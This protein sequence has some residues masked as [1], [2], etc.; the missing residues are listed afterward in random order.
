MKKFGKSIHGYNPIEVNAFVDEVIGQV[1]EMVR[2][3][4]LRDSEI[5]S[6]RDKL[7]HYQAIESTLNRAIYAAEEASDQ[8]K[9]AARQET[10]ILLEDAKKN[11]SRIVNE[12][13][14]RA[15]RTEYEAAML[16]KNISIFK[17]R[18]RS[19]IEAQLETVD[20]IDQIEL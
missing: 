19:I 1:E 20:E 6:L 13:L 4:Q 3:I 17:R 10:N 15:E 7:L 5:D 12:A 11:A 8:I 16:Q 14:M 2:Q 18:L 9:K